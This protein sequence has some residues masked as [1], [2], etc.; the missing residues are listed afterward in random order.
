MSADRR[1]FAVPD[2]DPWLRA[3]VAALRETVVEP[4]DDLPSAIAATLDHL[5]R[6]RARRLIGVASAGGAAALVVTGAVVRTRRANT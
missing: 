6:R 1:S 3:Q 4:G 2:P 5:A